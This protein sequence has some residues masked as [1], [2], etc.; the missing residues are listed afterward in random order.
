MSTSTTFSVEAQ[1]AQKSEQDSDSQGSLLGDWFQAL[2]QLFQKTK[3]AQLPP[4]TDVKKFV[5]A[6]K[7]L[8]DKHKGFLLSGA[9]NSGFQTSGPPPPGS[10]K[11]ESFSG[12]FGN[13]GR[14]DSDE[15]PYKMHATQAN[16]KPPML[17]AQPSYPKDRLRIT[18]FPSLRCTARVA[19]LRFGLSSTSRFLLIPQGIASMPQNPMLQ[20]EGS[21]PPQ[22]T[23]PFSLNGHLSNGA[24]PPN[25]AM[26]GQNGDHVMTALQNA[27]P[28]GLKG[29]MANQQFM[30]PQQMMAQQQSQQQRHILFQQ[31]QRFLLNQQML[32]YGLLGPNMGCMNPNAMV[33]IGANNQVRGLPAYQQREVYAQHHKQVQM[34]KLQ[35]HNAR[36]QL[37]LSRQTGAPGQNMGRPAG[38]GDTADNAGAMS[39]M[40]FPGNHPGAAQNPLMMPQMNVNV[41]ANFN[42]ASSGPHLMGNHGLPFNGSNHHMGAL[43]RPMPCPMSGPA[44][45]TASGNMNGALAQQPGAS[46]ATGGTAAGADPLK[47]SSEEESAK[48]FGKFVDADLFNLSDQS[49]NPNPQG[50]G[51]SNGA[52]G[53]LGDQGG[54][55][56]LYA[57]DPFSQTETVLPT[58][59]V[60]LGTTLSV[61]AYD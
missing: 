25:G 56:D 59:S 39:H 48:M 57:L 44:R 7:Y 61:K 52:G 19:M 14:R 51:A 47:S 20:N 16:G 45:P 38:G 23:L 17:L 31:N 54:G 27:S 53:Q 42:G 3:E 49:G 26:P 11:S 58:W 34:L 60:A 43:W 9:S 22:H 2:F 46:P 4:D 10:L 1:I 32:T 37:M 40:N 28:A 8:F 36:Q 6:S 29:T 41:M 50:I 35:Q 21:L 15:P 18:A 24:V 13:Q 12:K 55:M 30:S 33:A 5:E